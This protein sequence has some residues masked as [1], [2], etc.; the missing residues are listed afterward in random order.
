MSGIHA[1]DTIN[2]FIEDTGVIVALAYL[3]ARG[4]ALSAMFLRTLEARPA[5]YVGTIFGCIGLTEVI[6]PGDRYPYVTDTLITTL[7]ALTGGLNGSLMCTLVISLGAVFLQPWPIW[8]L[9]TISVFLAMAVSCPFRRFDGIRYSPWRGMIAGIT[10]QAAVLAA[11]CLYS[12]ISG[13]HPNLWH[14]SASVLANGFGL[15][16]MVVVINDAWL[17]VNSERHRL[18]AERAKAL[19]A[20]AQ[21]TS[22]RARIHP[23]FLYN[24]LASIAGMCRQSP[25]AERATVQLSDLMRRTL[26]VSATS[27][28]PLA[29]ELDHVRVYLE[30]EQRRLGSRL[31]VEWEIDPRCGDVPVPPLSVQTLVENA[32]NHGVAP[33]VEPATITVATRLSAR[34][35]LVAVRDDGEGMPGNVRATIAASRDH[36]QHGLQLLSKQL[37]ILF[38]SLARLRIYSRLGAGTLVAFSVPRTAADTEGTQWI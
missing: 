19:A 18:D 33:K 4:Q 34:S 6:F 21:L 29:K 1:L 7:A 15:V 22:L 37:A 5:I 16:L 23:H 14:A 26:E 13:E 36:E 17:R 28:I 31:A 27:T 12:P 24:V 9:T 10:A 25:E 3:I 35:V 30:I 38:G 11:T 8:P 32:V 20:Q 2:A